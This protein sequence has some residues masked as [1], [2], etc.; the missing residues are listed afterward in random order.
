MKKLSLM[1]LLAGAPFAYQAST[2]VSARVSSRRAIA[3]PAKAAQPAPVFGAASEMDDV[4]E[5]AIAAGQIPGAV[6]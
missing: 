3:P 2:P 4:I 1:L 6:V 5:G